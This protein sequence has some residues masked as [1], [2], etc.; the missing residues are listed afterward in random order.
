MSSVSL[1][2]RFIGC[3]LGGALGDAL[4][5]ALEFMSRDEI[6]QRYGDRITRFVPAFGRIGANTDDTQMTL[7]T[8][9]GLIRSYV[10]EKTKGSSYAPALVHG[11]YLRWL[12]TQGVDVQVYRDGINTGW[13]IE[14]EWLHSRRAPGNTCLTALAR[15]VELGAPARNDSKGCGGVMRVAP[16][17]L[18]APDA[19]SSFDLAVECAALTHG[20]PSGYLAAGHFAATVCGLKS[21]ADLPAS[22]AEATR[23]LNDYPHHEEVSDAVAMAVDLAGSSPSPEAVDRLGAGWVAEDALAIALYCALVAEDFLHGVSLAVVHDG[24][25]DSTGAMTGNVLGALWGSKSLPDNL[26][27]EL[28]GA[29]VIQRLATDIRRCVTVTAERLV[30]DGYATS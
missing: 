12:K 9:E 5:A 21:G 14:E 15:T 19:E 26:L 22:I 10:R 20:H 30:E 2:E 11:A 1:E 25:S 6:R 27:G 16:A 28:E 17:G 24:D 4:G 18:F 23:I 3:L 29:E 8:A 7:F 13:L